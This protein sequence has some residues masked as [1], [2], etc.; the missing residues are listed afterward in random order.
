MHYRIYKS[1]TNID[2]SVLPSTCS[3]AFCV[4]SVFSLH[5]TQTHIKKTQ[6]MVMS[7]ITT[8]C[9][10][11]VKVKATDRIKKSCLMS[12]HAKSNTSTRSKRS[13]ETE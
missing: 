7:H 8:S 12:T 10:S 5:C 3:D 6:W 2:R 4:K 9:V 13:T 11:S 1:K